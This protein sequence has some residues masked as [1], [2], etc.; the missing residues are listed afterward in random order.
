[1]SRSK[2]SSSLPKRGRKVNPSQ[3]PNSGFQARDF[4]GEQTDVVLELL[5]F[6]G[7]EAAH[8]GE[9]FIKQSFGWKTDTWADGR[10]QA[11]LAVLFMGGVVHFVQPIGE[12]QE[13]IVYRHRDLAGGVNE[14]G[15]AS[16]R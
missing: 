8:V 12:K 15:R 13:Q 1:M 16:C 5:L 6:G 3:A 10:D 9:K 11:V 7:R 4:H 14:I 2:T